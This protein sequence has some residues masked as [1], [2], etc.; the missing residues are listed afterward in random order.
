MSTSYRQ[1]YRRLWN[2]AAAAA[3]AKVKNYTN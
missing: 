2:G 1:H 3:G